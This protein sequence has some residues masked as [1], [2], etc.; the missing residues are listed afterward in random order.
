MILL[1]ILRLAMAVGLVWVLWWGRKRFDKI[2][3]EDKIEKIRTANKEVEA[4]LKAG[5]VAGE[6]TDENRED[7]ATA[8]KKADDR[9][10]LG[11]KA[12]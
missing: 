6:V 5:A 4:T 7:L 11:E 3:R 12:K 9:V 10:E 1:V 8:I 2:R